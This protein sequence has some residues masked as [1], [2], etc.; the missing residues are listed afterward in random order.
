[1]WALALSP[2]GRKLL[3][4]YEDTTIKLWDLATGKVQTFK[5]H[6]AGV[7]GVGFDPGG[8]RIASASH[9]G[10]VRLWDL[11]S[12]RSVHTF[13]NLGSCSA[14]AFSPDG[15]YLAA[16]TAP[17]VRLWDLA[18]LPDPPPIELRGRTHS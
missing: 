3:G 11:E 4:G 10:T 16:G 18:S 15:R 1:V 5:G 12:G 13:P 9:D 8:R 7:Q 14:V 6:E 2:D 17:G